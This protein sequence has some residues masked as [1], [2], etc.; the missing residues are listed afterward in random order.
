MPR[1]EKSSYV[2]VPSDEDCW[3]AAQA[4]TGFDPGKPGMVKLLESGR[5]LKLSAD[6]TK[7]VT[8]MDEQSLDDVPDM[9][10]LKKLDEASILH[11]LRIRYAQD[12]IYTKIGS[13]LVA[14]NPF[15]VLTIYN[16]EVVQDYIHQSGEDMA[17]HVFGIADAAYRNLVSFGKDQSCIVS[18]E[19]GAG[20]TET[21]KL[22]LQYLGERSGGSDRSANLREQILEANPLMEAFGNAKTIRNDNSSRF[23]KLIQVHFNNRRGEIVGGS[24]T[25]Y[26]LEKSRLVQQA[27]NERNYHIFYQLCAAASK[28][29]V[30]SDRLNLQSADQYWY[31]NQS[32][33]KSSAQ[34][35]TIN[36]DNDWS[37]T[38]IAMDVM[39][40]SED[41]RNDICQVLAGILNL[42]NINF[43]GT[44]DRSAVENHDVLELAASQ[45]GADPDALEKALI[46]RNRGNAR[47]SVYSEQ[48]VDD[49]RDS[50]DALAK[51]TYSFLFDWLIERIN[52]CLSAQLDGGRNLNPEE[53]SM[54]GVL[55]IFGFEFFEHNSFEQLCINYCNEKLQGHFND[56]IFKLEQEEYR[57]ENLDVS[58][59]EFVDN[60]EV[61]ATL[62]DRQN[63]VF[64]ILD[65]ENRLPR[66]TDEGFLT[67]TLKH[68]NNFLVA[69]KASRKDKTAA[70][71]FIV[72]H[73]AGNVAYDSRGFLEKNRDL[74]LPDLATLG[75]Q[76]SFPFMSNLFKRGQQ[77]VSQ[78]KRRGSVEANRKTIGAQFKEQLGTLMSLLNSTEPHYVRCIKP[79]SEKVPDRFDAPLCFGQ[80]R[81]AGLLE[82]CR[83][84]KI[85]YPV[86][87]TFTEFVR[88]YW[89]LAYGQANTS[90]SPEEL[91]AIL[92][93]SG[94]LTHGEWQ[95]GTTKVFMR[96]AQFDT[97]EA[98]RDASVASKAII[99]QKVARGFIARRRMGRVKSFR[100]D[101]ESAMA[102]RKVDKIK[103]VLLRSGVL[104]FQG[105]HLSF[106]KDARELVHRLEEEQ[107]VI[108]MLEEAIAKKDRSALETAVSTAKNMGIGRK[109]LVARAGKT[110]ELIEKRKA[111]SAELV[112]AVDSRDAAKLAAAIKN[113]EALEMQDTAEY[114][115]AATLQSQV[116]QESAT[117]NDLQRA[118]KKKDID[119][120]KAILPRVAELGLQ[121]DALVAEAQSLSKA[122]AKR[123][124]A[125]EASM[126]MVTRS[127]VDA[128]DN[129]DLP[130][131]EQ[132]ILR[133]IELGIRGSTLEEATRMRAELKDSADVMSDIT[134]AM[135]AINIR[136][137]SHEGLVPSDLDP[138]SEAIHRA[139]SAGFD[140]DEDD[141]LFDAI[142]FEERM[143]RQIEVQR[144][145]DAALE[146]N[147]DAA[148]R[149]VAP[150]IQELGLETGKA[151]QVMAEVRERG[152][153]RTHKERE[154]AK[155]TREVNRQQLREATEE[156]RLKDD[157]M[158]VVQAGNDESLQ[159]RLVEATDAS[160]SFEKFY[161]IRSDEDYTEYVEED[162]K[163]YYA[164][165]KLCAQAK[166]IP[167]SI[168]DMDDDLSRT[169]VANFK[170]ILQYSGLM[171]NS[172]PTA[173]AGYVMVRGQEIPELSDEIYIQLMKQLNKNN[174]TLIL[175]RTWA[176]MC[177]VTRTFPPSTEFEP[178]VFN[179]LISRRGGRGLAGN[180]AHLCLIQL[181]GTIEIGPSPFLPDMDIVESYSSHPAILAEIRQADGS[182][183][184]IPV[185]PNQDIGYVLEICN[186]NAKIPSDE[187]G[188]YAIFVIDGN[189]RSDLS[190]RERLIRFYRKYNRAK[191]PYVDYFLSNWQG[192]EEAMFATL[193]KKYGP[194]PSPDELL[195]SDDT[196]GGKSEE[197][198]H[199]LLRLPVTAARSAAKLLGL[200]N[201][202]TQTPPPSQAWPLPWWASPGDVYSRMAAQDRA[203]VFSHKRLIISKD[204][205]Y[206]ERLFP[207]V[208]EAIR[209]GDLPLSSPETMAEFAL[210]DLT[211]QNGGKK[212]TRIKGRSLQDAVMEV[213]PSSLAKTL[214][215]T[216]WEALMI[217][218]QD[219]LNLPRT[220]QKL[221]SAYYAKAQL[222]ETFGMTT[223][224][225]QRY[226]TEKSMK[227]GINLFG[228]HRLDDEGEHILE[229][230]PFSEVH[231][232]GA[233][234]SFF[235]LLIKNGKSN[236]TRYFRSLTPWSLYSS[237]YTVTH[238][239]AE[240]YN[241]SLK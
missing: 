181:H 48:S 29:P 222:L 20:K 232:F 73:Y 53:H 130:A 78:G 236:E 12:E 234:G 202:N 52:E 206:N 13:I 21:T 57:R 154:E 92:E 124:A 88:R 109:S 110:L 231:K 227:L 97:I 158:R 198:S 138:L 11:N 204:E 221:Q 3:V 91:G 166:P 34:V 31:L 203:P 196:T 106:V 102:T 229:T 239:A 105:R 56:F 14:I 129:R 131:L 123:S 58:Q 89:P 173:M 116:D 197:S 126:R 223:F 201:D 240:K 169:A 35:P 135:K 216:E 191:L 33:G 134:A 165:T 113:A 49:A 237:V 98:A 148:L 44:T 195:L 215:A 70:F 145:I 164:N 125:A 26:L 137:R 112:A 233:S 32:T 179:F 121:G 1:F 176:L 40:V 127:L 93:E 85:G 219:R 133:A 174:K 51:A 241:A 224:T 63:G 213:I 15:K 81:S 155:A 50:R 186:Q 188:L 209:E 117:L 122:E 208:N 193:E 185:T 43:S 139:Q 160:Y 218:A 238:Y 99:L 177:M 228:L 118:V 17:P 41:E 7:N 22:F 47:E 161:K 67:K 59:V 205:P 150:L 45:L 4:E 175:D 39:G 82:V 30:L 28:D 96:N 212:V 36:D 159:N 210:I 84:R 143:H 101:L 149:E 172:F 9:V 142:A 66:G 80:L 180:F 10:S 42:G 65:E 128:I 61:L 107:H 104:P 90:S 146:E 83:I 46:M 37:N 183:V 27:E 184:H 76:S 136:A 230:I 64:A 147:S 140:E 68:T 235:W 114:R 199:S 153:A 86:R 217:E 38:I 95:I 100:N 87:K 189:Q 79:N 54:V 162:N 119:G 108:D 19:S 55:D 16:P 200:S 103:E 132:L 72:V 77:H 71:T 60:G 151:K 94:L 144:Q 75:S 214:P 74:L 23:G 2:F 152:A 192:T 5:R 120:I 8:E 170:A 225:C 211:I 187:Q 220:I 24:I 69:P 226:Q 157:L 141:E 182:R 167:K 163:Q 6:E 62:E 190:Y 115:D 111:A 171:S 178:Y 18:G 207:Q 194:E 168:L 25:Q 156:E